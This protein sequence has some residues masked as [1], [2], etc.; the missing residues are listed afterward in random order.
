M[1]YAPSVM[2]AYLESM[3]WRY[4]C[5]ISTVLVAKVVLIPYLCIVTNE[6]I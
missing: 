3:E 4:S 5:K 2:R 1:K 6:Y